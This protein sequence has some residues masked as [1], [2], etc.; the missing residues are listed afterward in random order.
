MPT[1]RPAVVASARGPGGYVNLGLHAHR[2]LRRRQ[3]HRRTLQRVRRAADARASRGVEGRGRRRRGVQRPARALPVAASRARRAGRR[4]LGCDTR[5]PGQ[6][7]WHRPRSRGGRAVSGL[8]RR[9]RPQRADNVHAGQWTRRLDSDRAGAAGGR[10]PER[11]APLRDGHGLTV[12]RRPAAGADGRTGTQ[13]TSTR[14]SVSAAPI[15]RPA[16]RSSGSSASSTPRMQL[17]RLAAAS[18]K[19]QPNMP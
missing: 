17:P 10:L 3:C 13:R 16:A 18:G 2:H 14:S 19:W 5:Q 15:A 4:I 1:A 9:R 11:D 7:R 8:A 6:S 12:S